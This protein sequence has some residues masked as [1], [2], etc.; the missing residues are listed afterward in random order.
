VTAAAILGYANLAGLE[1]AGVEI[2]AHSHTHRQLDLLPERGGG[3]R[4]DT[5]QHILA[6]ALGHRIRSFAFSH[7]YCIAGSRSRGRH[8]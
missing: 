1:A 4:A 7:G 6:E 5:Q 8:A 3:G 2:G